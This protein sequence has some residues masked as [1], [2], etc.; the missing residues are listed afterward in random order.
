MSDRIWSAA[1]L[2]DLNPLPSR[3]VKTPTPMATDPEIDQ[4]L[5]L[6]GRVVDSWAGDPGNA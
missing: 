1:T 4:A 3:A 5:V 2:R 6:L